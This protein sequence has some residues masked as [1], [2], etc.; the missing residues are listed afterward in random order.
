[1]DMK[2]TWTGTDIYIVM[3]GLIDWLIDWL[4]CDTFLKAFWTNERDNVT[5]SLQEKQSKHYVV[6]P[7]QDSRN[8]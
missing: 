4:H 6:S 1:M 7:K 3:N 2:R 5:N 8:Q